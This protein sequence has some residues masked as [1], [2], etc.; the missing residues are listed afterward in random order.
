MGSHA[1][2]M[3][4]SLIVMGGGEFGA[5][6]AFGVSAFDVVIPLPPA[7]L[8]GQFLSHKTQ[9]W[10]RRR[11]FHLNSNTLHYCIIHLARD[12]NSLV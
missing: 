1:R 11:L 8:F 10:S 9:P 12:D 5:G 4:R 3:P 2:L 7:I 6:A